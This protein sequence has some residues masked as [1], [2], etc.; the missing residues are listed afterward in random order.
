MIAR[1][2]L[3]IVALDKKAPI[4]SKDPDNFCQQQLLL[5]PVASSL[6]HRSLR[7]E[8]GLSLER[9]DPSRGAVAASELKRQSNQEVFIRS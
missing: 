7:S 3:A 6:Q 2:L 8:V 1:T 4:G 9:N 5:Q